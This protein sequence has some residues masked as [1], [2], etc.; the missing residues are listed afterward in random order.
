MRNQPH[1]TS[2]ILLFIKLTVY[3]KILNFR[4]SGQ[5]GTLHLSS[6]VMGK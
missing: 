6:F 2:T 5:R 3:E 4:I 1:K